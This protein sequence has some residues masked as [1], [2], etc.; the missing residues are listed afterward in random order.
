[1]P[2]RLAAGSV[3]S[4]IWKLRAIYDRL[5]RFSHVNPVSALADEGILKI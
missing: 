3:D 2:Y 4:L 5:G 1:M